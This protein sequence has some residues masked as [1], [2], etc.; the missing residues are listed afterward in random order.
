MPVPE[1][2]FCRCFKTNLNK[3]NTIT[4]ENFYFPVDRWF[5]SGFSPNQF[6]G[7]PV[8]C[9]N[10]AFH[11]IL[12]TLKKWRHTFDF[13]GITL[14]FTP[15]KTKVCIC[16]IWHHYKMKGSLVTCMSNDYWLADTKISFFGHRNLAGKNIYFLVIDRMGAFLPMQQMYGS[17][18][19]SPGRMNSWQ[20][21][22]IIWIY[23]MTPDPGSFHVSI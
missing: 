10:V 22:H 18:V 19:S 1:Q 16:L 8:L 3:N 13:T 2:Y 9:A 4:G 7:F 20:M 11:F 21:E 5:Q 14:L 17:S 23:D 6:L 15:L 12:T